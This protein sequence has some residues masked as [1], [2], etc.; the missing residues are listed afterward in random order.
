ML[1]V[2]VVPSP[3]RTAAIF[4]EI[5]MRCVLSCTLLGLALVLGGA[6]A[7]PPDA[8]EPAGEKEKEK[9]AQGAVADVTMGDGS[10]VRV[11]LVSES[12]E[13][14]TKYGRLKI[15]AADVRRIEFAYRAPDEVA[16]KVA[17]AVKQL[18]SVEFE[19]REAA[20]KELREIGLHAYPALEEAAKSADAEVAKRAAALLGEIREKVP[21]DNL[22]FPKKDRVITAEFTVTG[23]ITSP[24]LRAKT[25]Y[26]GEA[27]LK[28]VDLRVFQ[29]AGAGD[30][31]KLTVDAAKFGSAPNQ[32]M[33]TATVLE[34]GESLHL[35]ASGQ[36]DLWPQEPGQ[37]MTSA[38]GVGN[39][40]PPAHSAGSL[41][42]KIGE[43]GAPF[44]IGEKYD[45]KAAASGKLYLHIIPSHWGGPSAGSY[46]VKLSAGER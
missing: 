10:T 38:K 26:F 39:V 11:T 46:E 2:I 8:R 15:P 1:I 18:G 34:R 42:G 31:R 16:K 32:W 4:R 41:I 7:A 45:G 21:A 25:S 3:S 5:P 43:N 44:L 40:R 19:K 6:I 23:R 35:T 20:S 17:A 27:D 29:A 13:L 30:D 9:S 24:T 33:E 28:L 37:Y 36:V 22:T 14:E 12:V